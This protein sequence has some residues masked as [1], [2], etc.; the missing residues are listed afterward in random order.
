M[1]RLALELYHFMPSS[2]RS[3]AASL[4]GLQLRSWRYGKDTDSLVAAARRRETWSQDQWGVW[5]KERL[6]QMLDCAATRVPLVS[7]ITGMVSDVDLRKRMGAK[8]LESIR[9]RHDIRVLYR[10]HGGLHAEV[11]KRGAA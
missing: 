2:L 10:E 4:R 9:T 6:R 8:A 5:R 11:A 3:A 1:N 7:A